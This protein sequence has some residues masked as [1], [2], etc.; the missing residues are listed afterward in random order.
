LKKGRLIIITLLIALV[1]GA[2]EKPEELWELPPAGDETVSSV[3]MGA[4]YENVIFFTLKT[5]ATQLRTLNTWHIAFAT[6][7]NEN[8]IILNGGIGVLIHPTNDTT[9]ASTYPINSKTEWLWD[10]S[11]G[12]A[13]STA[14]AGWLDSTTNI[15]RNN[16]YVIDLGAK[17][18]VRYKK[19]KI[20]SV[21]ANDF[22]IQYANLDGADEHTLLV[23]KTAGSNYTYFNLLTSS[24]VAYEPAGA[25]WDL[26]FTYYR[27]IYYDMTPITPYAVAG[28]LINTKSTWVAET[29]DI[30][31]E[32][33]D[34]AKAS[35]F[36][37]TQKMDEIGY[38]WKT[39]DLNGTE[40]Y[41]V[42][43]KKIYII[44]DRE[45]FL[46]KLK[47]INFYDETGAKGVPQFAYQ[48][49]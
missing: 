8:H 40:K 11:G 12:E 37:L 17:A 5:G 20:L 38:D 23:A 39:Y 48:R 6:G 4:N 7:S 13:D 27:H 46:Y 21:S 41:T 33:L 35:K 45:G 32:N 1:F 42:N 31:F 22:V 10:N 9:F 19:I 15:S 14:F 43:S 16:V 49:L 26:V 25:D 29:D 24:A 47:F 18:T 30:A 28:A 36:K 44:K 2:C 3:K 34:Y